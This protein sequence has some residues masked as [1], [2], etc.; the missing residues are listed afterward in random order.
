MIYTRTQADVDEA[1]K[2][3]KEKV[4]KFQE[5]TKDEIKILERGMIT[6]NTLNRIEQKQE[7]LRGLFN[8][9]GYWNTPITIKV[10]DEAQLFKREDFQ[11]ILDNAN[12]LRN[13]FFTYKDTPNTPSVSFHYKDL[14]DLEKILFDL[15]V[16]ISDVRSKYK[17]CGTFKCGGGTQ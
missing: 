3:R 17:K 1:I 14:N 7:D 4:Q 16:M 9:M 13:A 12:T 2:I 15:D 5:L 11:R 8:S 10:W 6:V